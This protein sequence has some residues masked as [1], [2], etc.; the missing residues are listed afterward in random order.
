MNLL[1]PAWR[2]P[3]LF[4]N[5]ITSR[6]SSGHNGIKDQTREYWKEKGKVDHPSLTIFNW[7]RFG[8]ALKRMQKQRQIFTMKHTAGIFGVGKW[9]KRWKK[10]D[11]NHC[12]W[13]GQSEDSSHFLLCQGQQADKVWDKVF[14]PYNNGQWMIFTQR[15][16]EISESFLM[17]LCHI[18]QH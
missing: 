12:P 13:C 4:S 2:N 3:Q 5:T 15:D 6:R 1:R 16:P 17:E 8:T 7:M 14:I 10:W 11:H 9:M 18:S